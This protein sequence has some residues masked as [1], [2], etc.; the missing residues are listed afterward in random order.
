M[1]DFWFFTIQQ[2]QPLRSD[3]VSAKF[4]F[5]G[6]RVFRTRGRNGVSHAPGCHG[7]ELRVRLACHGTVT[8][9]AA[10]RVRAGPHSDPAQYAVRTV[11]GRARGPPR[12]TANKKT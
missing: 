9:N 2:G 5:G 1:H 3:R 12:K 4:F 7:R 6:R 11:T 10:H 8:G